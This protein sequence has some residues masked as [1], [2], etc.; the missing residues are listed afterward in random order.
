MWEKSWKQSAKNKKK[1]LKIKKGSSGMNFARNSKKRNQ[2]GILE[3]TRVPENLREEFLDETCH[4]FPIRIHILFVTCFIYSPLFGFVRSNRKTVCGTM[5]NFSK[6]NDCK[7]IRMSVQNITNV[8]PELEKTF[9]VNK[10]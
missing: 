10:L 9:K 1:L 4:V 7:V 3:I 2:R 6:K 8:V 5:A